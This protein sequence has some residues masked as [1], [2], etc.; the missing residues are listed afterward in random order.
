MSQVAEKQL[1]SL[2]KNGE[3]G[4]IVINNPQRN[5]LT[6]PLMLQ[7]RDQ[8]ME[9]RK[10]DSLKVVVI[11]S[12]N[13][14]FFSSGAHVPE[15]HKMML[16]KDEVKAMALLNEAHGML[17]LIADLGKPTVA[18]IRG[19]CL[20]GGSELA[21]ACTWRIAT[22]DAM[23]GQPEITLGI[24]PGMGGT[25]RLPRL[26]SL[27]KAMLMMVTGSSVS[28]KEAKEIGL[29]DDLVNK[30]EE[31]LTKCLWKDPKPVMMRD[32]PEE[33]E[34]LDEDEQ[35]RRAMETQAK[36]FPRA[37]EALLASVS[38][39]VLHPLLPA[40]EL[41]K[42]EFAALIME[43]EARL[44]VESF[45]RKFGLLKDPPKPPPVKAESP[46]VIITAPVTESAKDSDKS[47]EL[48]MLKEMVHDFCEKRIKPNVEKMEHEKRVL[49]E[50]IKEMAELG[51]YGVPFD[52]KYG[53]SGL[54][55]RGF[56]VM[57][58]EISK[59]HGST[60][61]M[62]G[63]HTSLFLKTIYLFGSEE[64][65][66]AWLPRGIAG[67]IIGAY[68][69]TE[70][71]VGSDVAGIT[72]FAKKVDGGWQIDGAKQFIS[73][74]AIA[75]AIV[76]LAQTDKEGGNKTQAMFIVPTK[77]AGYKLT[78]ETEEKMGLHASCTSAFALDDVFVPDDH[79][80]GDVGHG[81][82]IA[83]NVFNQSRISL[84]AGCVGAVERAQEI[85]MEFAKTRMIGG[86]PLFMKQLT[87]AAIGEIE[88]TKLAMEAL[89]EKTLG[90]YE[91]DPLGVRKQAAAVKFICAEWGFTA[92]DKALQVL[93]G[94]GY[95]GDYGME[96]ILRD[97]R[98][99]R[100][101]EGTS[102]VQKLLI[103]KEVIMKYMTS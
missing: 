63:A 57:M 45:L 22:K 67:E 43:D 69:T 52:E 24:I 94:S 25:Q 27:K 68:A 75:D 15:I 99:N 49:P 76:T 51:F 60:A 103:A 78:K 23:I 26:V 20:G 91:K 80:I 37:C 86:E 54:G 13:I 39:G 8:L 50:L 59:Y 89:Y 88:A 36:K 56:A 16:D 6:T 46:S 28:A 79:L 19:L 82:K 44:G 64:Q 10:D 3:I 98:V 53:G 47:E 77:S 18:F 71:N 30:P 84:G 72:T 62:L 21:L 5:E 92:I 61:V 32:F 87:Q 17:N 34:K 85:M 12:A 65:K 100:I 41:E 14:M 55:L 40:L 70:P 35:F 29:V 93:G 101:F 11:K 38:H 95:I 42:K 2:E 83:M 73:N 31:W 33:L 81:F 9:A 4:T 48:E 66:K 97:F 96:R 102:E 7:L 58:R 1:V 90:Q 74:G